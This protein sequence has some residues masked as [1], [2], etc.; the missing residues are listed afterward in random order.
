MKLLSSGRRRIRGGG[1]G[2]NNWGKR[3]DNLEA[4]SDSISGVMKNLYVVIEV[5]RVDR[6]RPARNTRRE[7]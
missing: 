1:E 5:M 3:E 6:E 7:N 2:G 4:T